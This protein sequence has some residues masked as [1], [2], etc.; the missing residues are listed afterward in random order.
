MASGVFTSAS[1]RSSLATLETLSRTQQSVSNTQNRLSTGMK[2]NSAVDGAVAYFQVKGL[3]S[4][5]SDLNTSKEMLSQSMAVVGAAQNGTKNMGETLMQMKTTV[6]AAASASI[7]AETRDALKT[8][9]N[10]LVK[11]LNVAS[12]DSSYQGINLLAGG[13][14][15]TLVVQGGGSSSTRRTVESKQ[16]D[17]SSLGLQEIADFGG[18]GEEFQ[19]MVT[20]LD[21]A[22]ST[23]SDRSRELGAEASILNMRMD[24]AN[25]ANSTLQ[26]GAS[27][28]TLSDLSEEGANLAALQARQ[29]I[30]LQSLS[31]AGQQQQAVLSLF[32]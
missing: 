22:L 5:A 18:S 15:N 20:K 17:A 26:E 12:A 1:L 14:S 4:R 19:A 25:T 7:D 21:A 8:N 3:D 10:D 6:A 28:L 16:L 31:L 27:K 24:F 32:R 29:Q 11:Q 30:G 23:V 9:Y 2:I 13:D